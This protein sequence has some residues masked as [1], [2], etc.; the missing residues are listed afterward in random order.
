MTPHSSRVAV[1]TGGGTGIGLA[2]ARRMRRDGAS[3]AITGRDLSRLERVAREIGAHAYALDIRE[4]PSCHEAMARIAKELGPIRTFIANAGVGGENH[5]GPNDRWR[6][7]VSTNLDGTYYSLR[8]AIAHLAPG[9]KKCDLLVVSSVLGK[10]GVPGYT[11]YCASKTGLIGLVR[12][13][14]L[15]MAFDPARR[16]VMVNALCP[17]WVETEMAIQGLTAFA[18]KAGQT[19]EQA[20]AD[21]MARVPLGRMSA[22]DEVAAYVAWHTSEECV[23]VT[24]QSLNINQGS[25]ME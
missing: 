21:A 12:A 5:P 13:L 17:G 7:V 4:E 24:G 6:E 18:Q 8:A 11:A 20:R 2:I 16:H 9:P 25:F 19:L 1:V 23:G 3:V 22:P 14:S 10:F 15:E